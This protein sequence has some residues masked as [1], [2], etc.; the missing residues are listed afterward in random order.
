MKKF[1]VVIIGGGPAGSASGALLAQAGKS[2]L[3][4]EREKFPRF[5]IGESLIPFGNDVLREMGV[6]EKLERAGFMTKKGAEFTL[7]NSCGF[8]R[9]WF[10]NNLGPEHAQTF[11]V[12]RAPFDSLLLDHAR[13][14]GCAVS[15][16]ASIQSAD[17]LEE[18][19]DLQIKSEEGSE[20]IRASYVIDA[21]GR[22]AWVGKK[23]SLPKSDLGLSKKMAIYAHFENAYRNEGEAAGH[24][25]IIRMEQGWFWMIPLNEKKTSVGVVWEQE[26]LK[27]TG[28]CLEERFWTM[29][30]SS[31]EA[32]FRLKEATLL[33]DFHAT[34]DYSYRY[35][36]NAGSRWLMVGD[37]AGFV[38]PIFS[39]GVMI[40]LRSGRLAAETILKQASYAPLSLRTQKKYTAKIHQMT[41]VF[42]K[43]IELFYDNDAFAVFMNP[44]SIFKLRE[45]INR[46]VAGQ[47]EMNASLRWRFRLFRFLS[48]LQ[49]RFPVA[50]RL[51]FSE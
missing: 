22:E 50:P 1:D 33:G 19:V 8:Q 27:A 36:Q 9:F 37:S 47:T 35:H 14:K 42:L 44:R 46:L 6:W 32:S 28:T 21:S 34:T 15:Q 11:Q 4:V 7:S 41:G 48:W 30:R 23:L 25:T 3:I 29:I 24:I 51:V 16:P 13:E 18:S 26:K 20:T 39:S 43:M 38:D 31:K 12:E 2:V 5:H 17:F 49:K 45:T 40:A 10:R